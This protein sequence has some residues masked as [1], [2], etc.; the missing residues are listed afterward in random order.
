MGT[1]AEEHNNITMTSYKLI[2][3]T[4]IYKVQTDFTTTFDQTIRQYH[5]D[6]TRNKNANLVCTNHMYTHTHTH[7]HAH[8][9]RT[10]LDQK[11]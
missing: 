9:Q 2:I 5:N 7:T 3:L 11:M 4:Q 6:T 8:T 10:A 1:T